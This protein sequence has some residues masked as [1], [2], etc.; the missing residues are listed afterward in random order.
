MTVLWL[1]PHEGFCRL[2]EGER[3]KMNIYDEEGV[4][5]TIAF[6]QRLDPVMRTG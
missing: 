2:Y 4:F 5:V 6:Q 1:Q 3:W